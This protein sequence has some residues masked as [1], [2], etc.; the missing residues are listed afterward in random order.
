M[1]EQLLTDEQIESEI[2]HLNIAWSHIPGQGLVRVY[3]TNSYAQGL[4]LVNEIGRVAEDMG[5]YPDVTLRA[6]EV[7]LTITTLETG[8]VTDLDVQLA[9]S[10]DV[11][12]EH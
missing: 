2:E 9:K 7:V 6:N 12:V 1:S 5:H 11:L 8:G 3:E 4:M 10:I